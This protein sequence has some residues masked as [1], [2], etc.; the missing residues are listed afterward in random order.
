MEA[1]ASAGN[2]S[3][4]LSGK[5]LWQQNCAPPARA[6]DTSVSSAEPAICPFADDL[7]VRW[8]SHFA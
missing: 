5:L 4:V 7:A 1:P 8:V 2:H 6:A 3:K